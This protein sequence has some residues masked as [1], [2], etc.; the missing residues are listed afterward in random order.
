M[1][2]DLDPARDALT[3]ADSYTWGWVLLGAVLAIGLAW[4]IDRLEQ[5]WML[6]RK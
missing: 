1:S 3:Q 5:W 2:S 4:G 6:R